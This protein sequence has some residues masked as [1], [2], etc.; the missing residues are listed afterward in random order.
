M[1]IYENISIPQMIM[2]RPFRVLSNAWNCFISGPKT[3]KPFKVKF[4]C[5][6]LCNLKCVMCPLTKGLT[7]KKGL[8]GFDNFKKIFD[9]V[10]FP[11]VNLTGLGEPLLNPELFKII[12]YA[13]KNGS[14]VKLDTNGVLLNGENIR[15]LILSNPTIISVSIDGITKK[16]YEK[17]R[18]GA[19]FEEVIKNLKNLIKYRNDAGSKSEI[20]LFFVFQK[21][22]VHELLRFIEFGDSLGVDV[23]NGTVAISFGKAT[24]ENKRKL[25][26]EEVGKIKNGLKETKRKIK[27]RLNIESIEDFL[28]NPGSWEKDCGKKACYRPWYSPC[29]TWDGY[30]VPC[31]IYCDNEIVFGNAFKDSFMKVWNNKL[32]QEFRKSFVR[33][34]KGICLKCCCDENFIL[35]KLKPAYTLPLIRSLSHRKVN[36]Q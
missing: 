16:T 23:I 8:L 25:S 29:I 5:S 6:T 24:N 14:L 28:E 10:R 26:Q 15:R 21:E 31:D 36:L 7:R 30:V 12:E 20:H 17:I 32:A 27:A 2:K 33:G 18:K 34:R 19:K 1:P 22:N 3:G 11:Y 13:R 9:E 4:E 35:E